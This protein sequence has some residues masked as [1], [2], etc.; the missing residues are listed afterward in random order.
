MCVHDLVG[1]ADVRLVA[2]MMRILLLKVGDDEDK[3]G[4]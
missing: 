2:N 3:I 1:V 4:T